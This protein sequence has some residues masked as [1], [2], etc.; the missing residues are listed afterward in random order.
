[1]N[2]AKIAIGVAIAIAVLV[3][4]G[5]TLY[6]IKEHQQAVI[7]RFGKFEKSVQA[8]GLHA[9]LPILQQIT[10]YDKRLLD[11]DVSPT[12]I[13]TKDKRTLLVDSF[14]KWQII[15]PERFYKRMRTEGNARGRIKDI[16]FSELLQEFGLH[17][18]EEIV[19]INRPVF[20][21]AVTKRANEKAHNLQ[22]GIDIIDVR[23]KRADLPEE[24]KNAVFKRMREERKRIALE[25]RSE[26][27]EEANKIRA[28]A[29]KEKVIMLADAYE[30][31]QQIRGEGDA[32]SIKIYAKAYNE[33]A[34]FYD[35]MR[36]LE[37]YKHALSTD[38]TMILTED[39]EF[40]KYLGS[41]G[42]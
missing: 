11:H 13:V 32:T 27:E 37:A 9:K 24:N 6:I 29:D 3:L 22:M 12:E 39:S 8:P 20:M 33:D 21:E 16:I 1:M 14:S 38:S 31:E 35:F 7:L 36:S 23:I 2:Q 41:S 10:V 40:L 4:T 19:S 34:E 30:K 28:K 25:F 17:T 42:R 15:D 5:D 26:G 18:L